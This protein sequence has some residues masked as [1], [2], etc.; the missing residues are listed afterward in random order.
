M[1]HSRPLV[2]W[3]AVS[4][5]VVTAAFAQGTSGGT[6]NKLEIYLPAPDCK[7]VVEVIAVMRGNEEEAKYATKV[8]D[9]KEVNDQRCHWTLNTYPHRFRTNLIH[10]SLRLFGPELVGLGRTRCKAPGWDDGKNTAWIEF[11]FLGPAD[12]ITLMPDPSMSLPYAREVKGDAGYVACTDTGSLP[13]GPLTL[14]NVRD[15]D[16]TNETLRLRDF[17]SKKDVCG[18]L[19]NSLPAMKTARKKKGNPILLD[20]GTL[21]HALSLQRA[22]KDHCQVPNLSASAIDLTEKNLDK[23]GLTTLSLTVK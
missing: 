6:T 5:L 2:L 8:N 23:R 19:V 20:R 16:L 17:E 9:E 14:W 4:S 1:R 21:V 13:G 15:V 10:F 3:A 12:Q 7:A 22:G 11:K 18:L